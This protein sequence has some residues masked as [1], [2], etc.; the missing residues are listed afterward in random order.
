ME[1]ADGCDGDRD[2]RVRGARTRGNDV[3]DDDDDDVVRVR[4]ADWMECVVV[5][6]VGRVR[7]VRVRGA[8]WEREV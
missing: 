4:V 7:D 1:N 3:I 6:S 8:A 2:D 5:G